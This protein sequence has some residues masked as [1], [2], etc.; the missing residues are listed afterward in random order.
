MSPRAAVMRREY[1]TP[2][3]VTFSAGMVCPV[4]GSALT[5]TGR[6]WRCQECLAAWNYQGRRGQWLTDD[7]MAVADAVGVVPPAP[8]RRSGLRTT[9]LSAVAVLVAAAVMVAGFTTGAAHRGEQL[10]VPDA[11]LYALAVL[12]LVVGGSAIVWDVRRGGAR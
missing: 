3:D 7:V 9:V 11:A 2:R 12:I 10:P 4:D 6:G 1:A 8:V 5:V